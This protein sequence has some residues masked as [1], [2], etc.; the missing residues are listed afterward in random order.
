MTT[1]RRQYKRLSADLPQQWLHALPYW[2]LSDRAWRLHT[3]ALMWAIG[4]TNGTLP[5]SIVPTLLHCTATELQAALAEL[6]SAGLWH[7]TADG[8]L[9]IDWAASQ[10]TVE[11]IEHN[12]KLN[13][14]RVRQHRAGGN[15]E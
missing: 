4:R 6:T 14:E 10:S 12:R 13:R 1:S 7:R 9:V 8:W 3:H 5:E 2:D 15:T 11:Q